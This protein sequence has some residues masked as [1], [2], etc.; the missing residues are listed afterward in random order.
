LAK[1]VG[2][3]GA[4]TEVLALATPPGREKGRVHTA[5]DAVDGARAIVDFLRS[6]SL[7]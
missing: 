5:A 7:L 6:R 2:A 1:P 4:R 3:A